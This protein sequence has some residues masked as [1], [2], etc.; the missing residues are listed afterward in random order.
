MIS[1]HRARDS[2]T[3]SLLSS[4]SSAFATLPRPS[5]RLSDPLLALLA[6]RSLAFISSPLLSP[7]S[8][9]P[10]SPHHGLRSLLAVLAARSLANARL[11]AQPIFQSSRI[12]TTRLALSHL[13]Q[14]DPFLLTT[15]I[16]VSSQHH[17]TP[18][19]RLIHDKA[20]ALLREALADYS[21]AGVGASVGL[22]EGVLLLAEFLP[23]DKG[24]RGGGEL[25]GN[26]SGIGV[27]G[28]GLHGI[29]NRRS[30]AMTGLAIRAAYGLGREFSARSPG[31][32]YGIGE[33]FG[34]KVC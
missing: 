10:L 24:G 6:A 21:F 4:S 22:V 9:G 17:P 25:L 2:Q 27:G 26:T 8:F 30:W 18:A 28:E 20:Y 15:L 23:R 33:M 7:S 13:A 31:V 32:E 1:H 11:L 29:E 16:T 3:P 19:L 5:R 12:P 34:M 14:T